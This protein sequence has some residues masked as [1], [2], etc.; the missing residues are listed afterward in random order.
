MKR[1]EIAEIGNNG[2]L[3]S[4]GPPTV[5]VDGWHR[6]GFRSLNNRICLGNGARRLLY[7]RHVPLNFLVARV[8][9]SP[10]FPSFFCLCVFV[11]WIFFFFFSLSLKRFIFL[12]FESDDNKFSFLVLIYRGKNEETSFRA[13]NRII[14]LNMSWRMRFDAFENF[15]FCSW[16]LTFNKNKEV[17]IFFYPNS[18]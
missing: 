2:F 16:C 8:N 4:S 7:C 6:H 14:L 11:E 15:Y 17:E 18:L 9:H 3:F 10:D 5:L 13:L 1:R 12:I